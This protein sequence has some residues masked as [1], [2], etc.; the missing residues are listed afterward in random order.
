VVSGDQRD[1]LSRHLRLTWTFAGGAQYYRPLELGG[2]FRKRPKV[3][4][5]SGLGFI[6]LLCEVFLGSKVM[7][8]FFRPLP[9]LFEVTAVLDGIL[10]PWLHR[11]SLSHFPLPASFSILAFLEITPEETPFTSI[12]RSSFRPFHLYRCTFLILS[13]V[14]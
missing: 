8:V 2:L 6:F 9:P 7:V 3:R 14:Y 4:N 11:P 12:S 5:A 1:S 13:L 10:G